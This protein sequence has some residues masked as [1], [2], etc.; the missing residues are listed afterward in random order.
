MQFS[1]GLEDNVEGRSL[2]W[3]LGHPGCFAYGADGA[4]ALL[5]VPAAIQ[6]YMDWIAKH[7]ENWLS[8]ETIDVKQADGWNVYDIDES[9][10]RVEHGFYS[11]NAWFDHDWLPLS[12]IANSSI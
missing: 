4:S 5:A 1:I 6:D 11:V 7:S 2:A 12:A 9:Y 3:V 8:G 10:N